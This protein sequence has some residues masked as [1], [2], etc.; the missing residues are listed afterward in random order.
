MMENTTKTR[1]L[2]EALTCFAENGY[3]GTNL[4]DLA[5][6]LGLTKSA[7]YR[8]FSGKEAIWNATFDMMEAYYCEHFGSPD[9]IPE[10][11][12]SCDELYSMTM[13]ML[14]FTVNDPK[15][16]LTRRLLLSEQFHDDR[17]RHF[18]TMHFLTG[19]RDIYTKIFAEM[20]ENGILKKDDPE[21]L[22]FAYTAPITALIHLC[23]REPER[24]PEILPQFGSF[25]RHFIGTYGQG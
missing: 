1:I 2:E 13:R 5:A 14:D 11:P 6:R 19:T 4:R 20:M 18:A 17:A 10:T 16:I 22:A 9:N 23:D 12:D 15:V 21:M 8:H 3:K 7:L 24:K 25:V